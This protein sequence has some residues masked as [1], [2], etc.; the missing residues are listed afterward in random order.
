MST[1]TFRMDHYMI[2]VLFLTKQESL[3]TTSIASGDKSL[4]TA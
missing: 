3:Y 1:I 4:T 2:L